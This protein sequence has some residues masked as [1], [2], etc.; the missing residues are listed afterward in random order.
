MTS[1]SNKSWLVKLGLSKN[2]GTNILRGLEDIG[3][4]KSNISKD[5]KKVITN[6]ENANIARNAIENNHAKANKLVCSLLERITTLEKQ[7]ETQIYQLTEDYQDDLNSILDSFT[8]EKEKY[9]KIIATCSKEKLIE[10]QNKIQNLQQNLLAEEDKIQKLEQKLQECLRCNKK[11]EEMLA[12]ETILKKNAIDKTK[13]ALQ[14]IK[15]YESR[16]QKAMRKL[17]LADSEVQ[18][19]RSFDATV[20]TKGH[21]DLLDDLDKL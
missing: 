7:Y 15:I 19:A 9:E 1:E 12:N 18:K 3:E 10:A 14:Q 17:K 16:L 8:K 13:Q 5:F 11:L 6:L 4:L 20:L 2:S 21:R